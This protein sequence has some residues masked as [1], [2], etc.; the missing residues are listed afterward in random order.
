LEKSEVNVPHPSSTIQRPV[1]I[2]HYPMSN[3]K[4]I[5]ILFWSTGLVF[6][7]AIHLF[8]PSFF[9]HVMPPYFPMP[10]LLIAL[11]GV[12]E[13]IFGLT[14]W[15]KRFRYPV[16]IGII[17]MLAVYLTVHIYM[18]TGNEAIRAV[19]PSVTLTVSRVRLPLQF[20]FMIWVWWL[21]K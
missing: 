14:F 20:F 10:V 4:K 8:K 19:E 1:S 17:L 21:R 2:V 3:F 12:V 6:V 16:A 9:L 11:S 18:I 5:S 13:I 15:Q 7:G